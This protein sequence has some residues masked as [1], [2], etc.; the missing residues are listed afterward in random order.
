MPSIMTRSSN[1]SRRRT[2][3]TGTNNTITI[4]NSSK[5][6]AATGTTTTTMAEGMTIT[7]TVTRVTIIMAVAEEAKATTKTYRIMPK[8]ATSITNSRG[9]TRST[10]GAITR[11]TITIM[12]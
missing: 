12:L 9:R 7:R 11:I 6:M 10:L 1:N 4:S 2:I 8:M 3:M 5:T